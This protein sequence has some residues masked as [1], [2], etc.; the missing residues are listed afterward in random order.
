MQLWHPKQIGSHSFYFLNLDYPE[1]E[2]RIMDEMSNGVD[3]Y[4]DRR[5]EVTE[6]LVTWLSQNVVHY[7][8]K[9]VLVLG[10]GVGEETLVIGKHA[11]HIYIN[12]LAPV[13]L[14]L[15]GEQLE[16]NGITNYSTLEGRYEDVLLPEVDLV[17]ASFLVYNKET[18]T[19]MRS[20][21]AQQ[22]AKFILMNETLTEY[23]KFLKE[24]PHQLLFEK[25]D[26]GAVC[27]LL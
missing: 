6:H 24:T 18:L 20:F 12:D 8:D 23:K 1:V 5:W 4:Y 27:V 14:R 2:K 3:V 15:C 21:M 19:A 22:S 26:D 10:A 13:A 9:K 25:K 16:K 11:K 17:V 7:H